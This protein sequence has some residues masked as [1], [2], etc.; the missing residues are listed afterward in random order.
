MYLA[1]KKNLLSESK[2]MQAF[3]KLPKVRAKS[4]SY[5]TPNILP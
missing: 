5:P 4:I 3:P 2:L 1:M